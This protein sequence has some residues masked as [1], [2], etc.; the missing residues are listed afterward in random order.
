MITRFN[1]LSINQYIPS[2]PR[3]VDPLRL[4]LGWLG[5]GIRHPAA[6]YGLGRG[7]GAGASAVGEKWGDKLGW[8]KK[9]LERVQ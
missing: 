1:G 9:G 8:G 4:H 3:Y 5:L 7:S 6:P 2:P